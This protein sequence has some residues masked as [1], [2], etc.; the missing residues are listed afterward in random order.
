MEG[1]KKTAKGKAEAWR[2]ADRGEHEGSV[3]ERN[4]H[5]KG[6]STAESVIGF[7]PRPRVPIRIGNDA[8]RPSEIVLGG[9]GFW[10]EQEASN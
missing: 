3:W 8:T 7:H 9:N 5:N 10:S 4:E 1:R 2:T 6:P